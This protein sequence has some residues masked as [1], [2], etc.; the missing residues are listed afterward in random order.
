MPKNSNY[1]EKFMKMQNNAN[2][3]QI[4]RAKEFDNVWVTKTIYQGLIHA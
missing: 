3:M 2:K 1:A 4:R